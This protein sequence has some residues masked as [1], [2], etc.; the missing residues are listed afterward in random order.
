MKPVKKDIADGS[1]ILANAGGGY[2]VYTTEPVI[3]LDFKNAPAFNARWID[4]R[5]GAMIKEETDSRDSTGGV[6]NNP[7][8]G[9]SVLRINNK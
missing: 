1:Y 9:A 3:K 6:F 8:R 2:I 5:S 4:P 7:Q